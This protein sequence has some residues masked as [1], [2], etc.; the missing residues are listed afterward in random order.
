M[1][2]SRP[3]PARGQRE[4]CSMAKRKESSLKCD[5]MDVEL[6][7]GLPLAVASL[8]V[9]VVPGRGDRGRSGSQLHGEAS[10]EGRAPACA[11][12]C[13]RLRGQGTTGE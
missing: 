11:D 3:P 1:L 8:E 6:V 13:K 12:G 10:W 9:S 4:D 7:R 2:L 5:V